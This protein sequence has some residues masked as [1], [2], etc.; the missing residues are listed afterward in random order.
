MKDINTLEKGAYFMLKEGKPSEK[1][2]WQY[3]GYCR[4]NK[5]YCATKFTDHCHQ[6]YRKKGTKVFTDFEF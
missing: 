2:V 6:I 4:V 1:N 5:K 3:D